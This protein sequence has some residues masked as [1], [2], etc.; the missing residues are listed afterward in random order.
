[1][2]GDVNGVDDVFV[3]DLVTGQTTRVSVASDGTE[4]NY[5]SISGDGRYVAFSAYEVFVHD[6]LTGET[7]RVSVASDGTGGNS[8][9]YDPSISGDGRYVAFESWAS[10]LVAGDANGWADVFVHDR[11]T[12][13]TTRVS[14]AAD[15]TEGNG[16]S[17]NPSISGDGRYVAFD[18][19]ASSLVAE[20]TNATG[21]VF[22]H[23][24]LTAE[25]MRVSV[26]ADGTEGTNLS[27]IPSISGDGRHVAFHSRASNLVAGDTNG[28]QDV[29]VAPAR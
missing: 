11:L 15:G 10:N 16:N 23:D 4:G 14:V 12:G 20:D 22:V 25:T 19:S 3:H 17:Y 28:Q 18:S 8:V 27:Q 26:A 1:M 29:F 2:T 5:S 9:S 21:D 6:R 13:E 7:T 24:R